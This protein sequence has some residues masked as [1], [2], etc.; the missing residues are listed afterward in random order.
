MKHH[1]KL[2]FSTGEKVIGGAIL[3]ASSPIWLP[4]LLAM[5]IYMIAKL[6]MVYAPALRKI[7]TVPRYWLT[8]KHVKLLTGLSTANTLTLLT[9]FVDGKIFECRLREEAQ[10][11]RIRSLRKHVKIPVRNRPLFAEQVIYYEFRM[12][13]RGGRKRPTLKQ[14]FQL[15]A[16][17][18][19][20][21]PA[22]AR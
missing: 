1:K 10:L 8:W 22:Y 2:E 4:L 13:W 16:L 17:G 7:Q 14:L 21:Q 18:P 11:E 9:S 19:V 12:V 15:P 20:L 6:L 5:V 3:V